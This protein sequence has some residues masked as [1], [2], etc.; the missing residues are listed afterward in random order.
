MIPVRVGIGLVG[1]NFVLNIVLI[2]TP[3]REAGLAWSTAICAVLQLAILARLLARRTGPFLD[4]E[5]RASIL[6]TLAVTAAMIVAVIAAGR[7]LPDGEGWTSQATRLAGL[8]GVGGL[9][10]AA[11][12]SALRM[13]ELRWSLGKR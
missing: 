1:L 5:V 8:V 2:F 11:S 4:G 9:A 3:L 13:P 12:A 6:R 10:V 7:F